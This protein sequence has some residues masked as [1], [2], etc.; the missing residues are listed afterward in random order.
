MI[1]FLFLLY[2][3]S[4]Y[5]FT[6]NIPWENY[7]PRDRRFFPIVRLKLV[8][9]ILQKTDGSNNFQN[10]PEHIEAIERV[11]FHAYSI[12]ENLKPLNLGKSEYIPDSR[13]RLIYSRDQIYFHQNDRYNDLSCIG[14]Y[15]SCSSLMQ[16]IYKELVLNNPKQ[17]LNALHV[18]FG[19]GDEA[20]GEACGIGCKKWCYITGAYKQFLKENNFWISGGLLAHEIGHNL[21]LYHTV[22][23]KKPSNDY[24]DDTP[25]YP[26]NPDCWNGP[27]CSNNMMDY[28]ANKDALSACQ[29]GR[30]HYFL[31]S[32][33]P[34][35]IKETILKDW[36]IFHS[37]SLVN[38]NSYEEIIL[39]G[40]YRLQGNLILYPHST[41]NVEGILHL[42]Q[43]AYI[44][45]YPKSKLIVNGKITNLCGDSWQ[46]VL[47]KN[48]KKQKLK[49]QVILNGKLENC[50][51]QP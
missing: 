14:K 31:S 33:A 34:G 9:H 13:I 18:F 36:C 16:E 29:L 20:K 17:D 43:N 23:K 24:C 15:G 7:V 46:G 5:G 8:V 45:L 28:N 42:P 6:Q 1:R 30:I 38:I 2:L 27:E 39:K 47:P 19:E 40:E 35:D 26:E 49:E 3:L 44:L 32:K 50:L 12:Y 10:I 11:L 51:N 25:T 41:L 21:G 4:F 22:F 48:K 37:D